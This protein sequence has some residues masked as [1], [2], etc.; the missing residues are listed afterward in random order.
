M[1]SFEPSDDEPD[2]AT[3][4]EWEAAAEARAIGGSGPDVGGA[5]PEEHVDE[6]MRPVYEAGGG[7]AE[8]FELAER[9][10]VR[11][12]SHDDGAAFPERD[13]FTPETESDLSGADYGEA[14]EEQGP[15]GREPGR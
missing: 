2:F 15:S 9:D 3:R 11:N 10:L 13:G 4:Q 8:G 14:D 1:E 5:D 12:A 7:E 6:S